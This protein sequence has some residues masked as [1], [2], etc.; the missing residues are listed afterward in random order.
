M[1][2]GIIQSNYIPWKGYFD[3]IDDVDLF[4][5]HDDLQ[6]TKG[7]WRNRNKIKTETG[8]IWLSVPVKYHNHSQLIMETEIDNSQHWQQ[9]HLNQIKENYHKAQFFDEIYTEY[10]SILQNKFDTISELNVS[11][12]KW[13]L[14]KLKINTPVMMS[15]ELKPVGSKTERLIDLLT[16][17]R[18]SVY[19]SGPSAVSYLDYSKFREAGIGLEYK[20]YEYKEYKQLFGSFVESISILDLVFNQGLNVREYFKSLSKN[21]IVIKTKRMEFAA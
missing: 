8:T 19:L 11:L 1:K 7:D 6:Y 4:V 18:A 13:M 20:S 16:K 10:E 15:S 3:F 17:L 12:I 2:V 9:K 5:F 14:K 21:E